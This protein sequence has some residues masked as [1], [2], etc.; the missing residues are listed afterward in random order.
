MCLRMFFRER[1]LQKKQEKE[2]AREERIV[3]Q[4][5]LALQR[6]SAHVRAMNASQKQRL[7]HQLEMERRRREEQQQVL[8]QQITSKSRQEKLYT[9]KVSLAKK[10]IVLSY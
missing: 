8:F 3:K 1:E 6:F 2:K 5:E 10:N 7:R 9:V 4:R